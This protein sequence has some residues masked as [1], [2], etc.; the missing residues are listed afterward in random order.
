M[1]RNVMIAVMLLPLPFAALPVVGVLVGA[2]TGPREI[3]IDARVA[4][5]SAPEWDLPRQSHGSLAY[6]VSEALPGGC[7]E[8]SALRIEG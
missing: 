4:E 6:E 1:R 5:Y 8:V 7:G 3:V 2:A